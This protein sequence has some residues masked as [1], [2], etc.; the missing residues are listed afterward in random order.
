M[1]YPVG[2]S[3]DAERLL[4]ALWVLGI[5]AVIVASVQSAGIDWR[6]GVLLVCAIIA[7][8]A[9]WTGVFRSSSRAN[10]IFDGQSWSMSGGIDLPTAQAA[11]MLDLQWLLLIRLREPVGATRWVWVE[12]NA[13]PQR[14]R[15]LRRALYS[16]A[17]QT[18][19][20]AGIPESASDAHHLSS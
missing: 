9:A 20:K 16:R 18:K 11:V 13:M 1:I 6:D 2:R 17:I 7:T 19:A 12:R 10:L 15:D 14:W 3:R 4:I 8:L 5:C